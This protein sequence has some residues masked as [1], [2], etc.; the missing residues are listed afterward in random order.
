MSPALGTTVPVGSSQL[1]TVRYRVNNI[2][3]AGVFVNFNSTAGQLSATSGITDANGEVTVSISAS[4][5]SP[6]I[7]QASFTA[8][9]TSASA[10]VPI[11]FVATTPSRLVLQITPTA[12]PP[13]Q[14]GSTTNQ[15]QIV[16]RVTDANG[17]PVKNQTVNFSRDLD[18]SGGNLPQPSALTDSGG[19]ATVQ[20]V[21]GLTSTASD[22]VVLRGAVPGTAVAGTA[23][24]TV[25]SAALF[26]ALGTGNTIT[27]LDAE[28]YQK[29][30]TVYV[31]DANGVAVPN[32][33]LTIKALPTRYRKGRL[34]FNVDAAVWGAVEVQE[35]AG[36]GQLDALGNLRAGQLISCANEDIFHGESDTSSFN[37]TLDADEDRNLNGQLEPGNVI[38]VSPGT[39]RTDIAGRA[40]ISLIYAESYVPWIE[41]RLQVQAIV[42]GTESSTR[43]TFVVSGL[44]ADFTDQGEPPAGVD[45]PYGNAPRCSKAG[46]Y[47]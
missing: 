8:G 28:T 32:V 16:A 26:I 1:L 15:A 3:Q 24:L 2:A 20:Y 12:I 38:S 30:Y 31:T 29:D 37:G 47:P 18:L 10:T 11:E 23:K 17:N 46:S 19:Q 4:T 21:S 22:G 43:S 14:S 25:N 41:L 6:A 44:A 27:N 40:K 5:A 42:S 39:L 7:V 13:N 9:G 33:T 35:G 36:P 45:S 34:A